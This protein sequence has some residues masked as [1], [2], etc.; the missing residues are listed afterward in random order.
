MVEGWMRD[1][2]EGYT[3]SLRGY[4]DGF[5]GPIKADLANV[6]SPPLYTDF[7][8]INDLYSNLCFFSS[9]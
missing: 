2:P 9:V 6:S 5:T 7:L 3:R 8:V 4:N 1:V